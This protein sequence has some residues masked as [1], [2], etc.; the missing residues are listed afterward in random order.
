LSECWPSLEA[1][2]RVWG[3]TEKEVVAIVLVAGGSS[4]DQAEVADYFFVF[5]SRGD[6]CGGRILPVR[7]GTIG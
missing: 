5:D 6:E 4:S 2:N 7:Q 3:G 1:S